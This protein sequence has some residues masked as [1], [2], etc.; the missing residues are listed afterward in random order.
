MH[1]IKTNVKNWANCVNMKEVNE[2][3]KFL[4][5]FCFTESI[6]TQ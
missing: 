6:H 4:I 1:S 3:N 2:F 5:L